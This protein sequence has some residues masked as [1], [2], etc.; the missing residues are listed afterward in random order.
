MLASTTMA[1]QQSLSLIES[2]ALLN[3]AD[4]KSISNLYPQLVKTWTTA[5]VF[6]TTTEMW[7]SVLNDT[8]RP[9]P[10]SKYWQAVREQDVFLNELVSLSYEYRKILLQIRKLERDAKI[11]NGD[12]ERELL[13]LEIDHQRWISKQIERTAHHRAREITAWEEIKNE[14]IPHLKYGTE[15]V[16]AHQL[17]AMRLRWMEEAKLVNEHTPPADATNILGLAQQ[18]NKL[19]PLRN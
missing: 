16:N 13:E 6:R 4:Q 8:K 2:S 12:I 15:D 18:A 9:T 5:Q 10:D 19:T 1:T 3:D 17:E 7:V 11:E 14:L